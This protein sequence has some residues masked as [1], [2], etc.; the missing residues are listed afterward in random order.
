MYLKVMSVS[1]VWKGAW[2]EGEPHSGMSATVSLSDGQGRVKEPRL[3]WRPH[4]EGEA[5]STATS[6]RRPAG[7]E[8]G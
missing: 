5:A 2:A 7:Y 8:S 3:T 4:T 1:G 6:Q